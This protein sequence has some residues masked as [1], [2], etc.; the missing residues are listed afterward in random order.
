MGF[1]L[2]NAIAGFVFTGTGLAVPLE[3]GCVENCCWLGITKP[4][5]DMEDHSRAKTEKRQYFVEC[6]NMVI[7]RMER[8]S[9]DNRSDVGVRCGCLVD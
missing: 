4:S 9:M 8:R 3:K 7:R 1:G 6:T 5:T 2:R